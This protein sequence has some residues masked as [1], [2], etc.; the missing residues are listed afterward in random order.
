M[1]GHAGRVGVGSAREEELVVEVFVGTVRAGKETTHVEEMVGGMG[2][3]VVVRIRY[4]P[5]FACVLPDVSEQLDHDRVESLPNHGDSPCSQRSFALLFHHLF[6]FLHQLVIYLLWQLR[7]DNV[8]RFHIVPLRHMCPFFQHNVRGLILLDFLLG[9]VHY[10][11][12][13]FVVVFLQQFL[14]LRQVLVQYAD[15]I[16]PRLTSK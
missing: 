11:R 2:V 6:H 7:Y 4:L 1:V 5:P 15:D 3:V 14:Y 10:Q 9:Y 8:L 16:W 12:L 13:R